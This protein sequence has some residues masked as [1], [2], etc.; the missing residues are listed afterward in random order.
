MY[1]VK[2][3]WLQLLLKYE[4]INSNTC[5]IPCLSTFSQPNDLWWSCNSWGYVMECER[6]GQL[7][8]GSLSGATRETGWRTL[9]RWTGCDNYVT[10]LTCQQYAWS[11]LTLRTNFVVSIVSGKVAGNNVPDFV[12]FWH[13]L[14][15]VLPFSSGK[16]AKPWSWPLASICY[17]A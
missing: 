16:G 15:P 10:G 2:V 14:V 6:N 12:F 8:V 1:P 11:F 9:G 7:S 5:Y 3:F 17:Q 13:W 4:F